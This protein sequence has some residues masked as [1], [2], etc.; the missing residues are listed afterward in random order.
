M[1]K[2]K[3]VIRKE[4]DRA[5]SSRG[6]KENRSPATN[7]PIESVGPTNSPRINSTEEERAGIEQPSQCGHRECDSEMIVENAQA[8]CRFLTRPLGRGLQACLRLQ[9]FYEKRATF[10]TKTAGTA[11][12]TFGL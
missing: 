12:L 1:S 9:K 10:K 4:T 7:G 8:I 5:S 3:A 6:E 2:D 11:Y